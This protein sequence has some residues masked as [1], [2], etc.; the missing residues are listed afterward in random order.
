MRTV[1]EALLDFSLFLAKTV[2]L[3]AAAAFLVGFVIT[4]SRRSREAE[5]LKV[6]SLNARLRN[7]A[8]GLRGALLPKPERRRLA[9]QRK[10]EDKAAAGRR[11]KR[12]FV[13]D[14]RGDI[15]AS[16]TAS[17]REEISAVLAVAEKGDEVLMR[18]E[19]AGGLVHEHG[20]AASQLARLRERGVPLTVAVD[21]VAA[22]GGY[23]MACV[24]DRVMAAPFAI[25]G[26]IGVLAQ[27][28][29]FRR[30]LDERGVTVE[31]VKAGRYKRTVSMFGEVTD[32]DRDKLRDELEDVHALFQAMVAKYRPH[33]D[34]ALV[35]TGEHWYGTRALELGL[36]DELGTSDDWLLRVVGEADVWRVEWR[37]PKRLIDKLS[38]AMEEGRLG[39]AL[40]PWR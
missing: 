27:I 3:V 9:K 12:V 37:G 31:Q 23:L 40:R 35:A 8:D 19:N 5:G 36:V 15:R 30:M 7:A 10:R 18:L 32:E 4:A 16:A 2:T 13:L 39:A 28:P 17:M 29:N 24:A 25:V 26:S 22:S 6:T 20:L 38:A 1:T 11:R 33:L 14:F 34:L 21:K